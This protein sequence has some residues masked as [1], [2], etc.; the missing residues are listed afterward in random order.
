MQY[1][2]TM[3]LLKCL[4]SIWREHNIVMD[5]I[6]F[7]YAPLDDMKNTFY[8]A[9][10]RFSE[11]QQYLDR[12]ETEGGTNIHILSHVDVEPDFALL[13]SDGISNIGNTDTPK[14]NCLFCLNFN[15]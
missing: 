13:I 3:E 11:V 6:P 7:S 12:L 9:E 4:Y 14:F 5:I 2:Q 1:Q 8:C 10:G 15:D